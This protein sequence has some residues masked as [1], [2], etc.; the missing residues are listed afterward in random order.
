MT[1]R[2][3]KTIE[4]IINNEQAKKKLKVLKVATDTAT[5]TAVT[6]KSSTPYTGMNIAS[7][8]WDRESRGSTSRGTLAQWCSKTK[9]PMWVARNCRTFRQSHAKGARIK[10]FPYICNTLKLILYDYYSNY[11]GSLVPYRRYCNQFRGK[12]ELSA[13]KRKMVGQIWRST[14]IL[15][16]KEE[17][18]INTHSVFV[19]SDNDAL[20]LGKTKISASFLLWQ[21]ETSKPLN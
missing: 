11:L 5:A 19:F 12:R 17:K 15:Y 14:T 4:L 16:A 13:S 3:I 10:I 18:E 9:S 1:D 2:D 21:T 20:I 8:K 7:A 6:S